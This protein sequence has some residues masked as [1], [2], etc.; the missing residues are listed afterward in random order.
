MDTLWCNKLRHSRYCKA[1]QHSN[2]INLI[3]KALGKLITALSNLAKKHK[4][5]VMLGRTHGQWATPIT[6]GLK[7]AVFLAEM[8]R[9]SERLSEIKPRIITGKFLGAVGSGAAIKP[10]TLE[11]T[12]KPF[13]N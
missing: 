3:E 5:T 4:N 1:L 11:S 8:K 13:V 7:I 2:A 12:R 9:H 6:F 10:H